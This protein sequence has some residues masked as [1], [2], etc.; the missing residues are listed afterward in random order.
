[1]NWGC[2]ANWS[3]RSTL[4]RCAQEFTKPAHDL[5]PSSETM[6][7][8]MVAMM[9]TV[10][11]GSDQFQSLWLSISHS[12]N[13]SAAKSKQTKIIAPLI[14]REGG[15]KRTLTNVSI[16]RIGRKRKGAQPATIPFVK[17]TLNGLR[18]SSTHRNMHRLAKRVLIH[19]Q[20]Y[21]FHIKQE[22]C[23]SSRLIGY[24]LE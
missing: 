14:R 21:T 22:C 20:K 5:L 7:C 2:Q 12:Q 3:T 24:T 18:P 6:L 17:D 16:Q 23:T 4:D 10:L 8:C 15:Q 1:M 11:T 13:S 19:I 9:C